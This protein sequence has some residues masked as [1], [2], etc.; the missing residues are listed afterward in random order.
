M[1]PDIPTIAESGVPYEV[2]N[3]WGILAPAG[4]PAAIV[5]RLHKDIAAIQDIPDMQKQLA[6]EGAEVVNMTSAEFGDFLV[7]ETDKW[8][9]VIK[10][11]GIKPQ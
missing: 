1:L 6:A 7:R 5:E 3:W 9:R 8:G 4:T 10:E 11:G 2:I